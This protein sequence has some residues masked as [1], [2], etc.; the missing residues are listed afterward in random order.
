[1]KGI[2]GILLLIFLLGNTSA[3]N[4]NRGNIKQK[5]TLKRFHIKK[6]MDYP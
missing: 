2:L 5:T 1:M 4:Y 6:L 3:Q